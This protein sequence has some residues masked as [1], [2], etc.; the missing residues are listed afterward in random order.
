VS[1]YFFLSM[2]STSF[3][4]ISCSPSENSIST[5][6]AQTQAANPTNTQIP[7]NTTK[8]TLTPT[9]TEL[10]TETPTPTYTSTSTPI[11]SPTPDLRVIKEPSDKFLLQASDLPPDARYFLPDSSWIS[12]HHNSE[13]ISGWGREAGLEYLERTGRIDG[14][15]VYYARGTRTVRAPEEIFHNIIQYQ[16]SDG[17]RLTVREFNNVE[18]GDSEWAYLEENI[19]LGDLTVSLIRK[20]MQPNGK[21]KVDIYIKTAYR[22]YV[23]NIAGFGWED[24][25][26]LEYMLNIARIILEKLESAQLS[27][28]N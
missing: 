3:L 21:Y 10:P 27:E 5:A 12:P 19:N 16:I 26:T 17:A 23:S 11:P 9:A 24:E 13:I 14:W 7:T 25:V 4:L 28:P 18:R 2:F 20:R 6:I 22:N 15:W 1:K 8:P